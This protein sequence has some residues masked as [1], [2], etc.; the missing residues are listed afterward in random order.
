VSGAPDVP[1]PASVAHDPA[2]GT[3]V[4]V[5][6]APG[7]GKTTASLVFRESPVG[8]EEQQSDCRALADAVTLLVVSSRV[9]HEHLAVGLRAALEECALVEL[10]K[11][12]LAHARSLGMAAAFDA[13]VELADEEDLSLGVAARL[14]M[15]QARSGTLGAPPNTT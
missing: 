3:L 4:C 6:G 10:A 2:G 12:A 8:F 13:L 9:E 14:V 5:G 1:P 7:A 15:A 11:G